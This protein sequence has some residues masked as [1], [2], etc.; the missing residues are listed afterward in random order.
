MN[1]H[2]LISDGPEGS[3]CEKQKGHKGTHSWEDARELRKGVC[4]YETVDEKDN[5]AVCL[6]SPNHEGE[7]GKYWTGRKAAPKEE[8]REAV[9]HPEHYGGD[10]TY[11]AIKVID[12]WDLNFCLGNC[13]KYIC[14][15][16]HKGT[17]LEDLKKAAW[18]LNHYIEQLEKVK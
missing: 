13:V 15:S 16:P 12:A 6:G 8:R 7:H 5:V 9:H 4:G 14:R 2:C 18:Y 1:D 11:E 10:T 3:P 17:A